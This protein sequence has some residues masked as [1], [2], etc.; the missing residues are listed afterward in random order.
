MPG[1]HIPNKKKRHRW[2]KAVKIEGE[3]GK[4][5]AKKN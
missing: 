1:V 4:D 3:S 2:I 5:I